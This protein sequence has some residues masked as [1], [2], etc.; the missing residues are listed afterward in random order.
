MEIYEIFLP[1][2]NITIPISVERKKIKTCRLKVFPDKTVRFSVPEHTPQPW[3]EQYLNSKS[4][5]LSKKIQLFEQTKGYAATNEIR[6]GFSIRY[7]GEDLIFSIS[8]SSKSTVHKEGK[9]LYILTPDINDQDKLFSL[10][11]KWW[12]KESAK[13]INDQVDKLYSI[14]EKY[15]IS[16]PKVML[17]KMKTLWGSCS[18]HRGIITFNQYLT[19]APPAC[20]EYVV[21]HELVHFLYPNH[22]KQFYDFLSNY[23]PD[24]KDRKKILDQ[25]VVH[26]L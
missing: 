22:S 14:I 3:I 5:W 21:L 19:K 7:L 1:M 13:I 25:N 10:F 17:R 20:I 12:R 4:Q 23:M 2:L 24:W 18:P 8:Q 9:T 6:N 16:R 26:G 11:D 15:N